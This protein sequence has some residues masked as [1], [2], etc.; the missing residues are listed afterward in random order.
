LYSLAQHPEYQA[1][2]QEEL[3]SIIGDGNTDDFHWYVSFIGEEKR[4]TCRKPS[5]CRKSLTNFIT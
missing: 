2:A 3:D 1:K 4:S 5:T